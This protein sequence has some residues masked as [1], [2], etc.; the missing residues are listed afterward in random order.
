[1]HDIGKVTTPVEII[2]KSK[3][4][5]T[6]FDRIQFVDMRMQFIIQKLELEAAQTQLKLIR[7]GET[8]GKIKKLEENT[9]KE[10][11][12]LKETREFIKKCNEPSE[13]LGDEYIERLQEIARKTYKDE[14]GNEQPLLTPDELKNLINP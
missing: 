12:E 9:A 14:Q 3:K 7:E 13:F 1:M 8:S 2:E 6:I 10:V 4:L 11:Q 5:E